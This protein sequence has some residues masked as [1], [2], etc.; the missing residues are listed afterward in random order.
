MKKFFPIVLFL[1]LFITSAHAQTPTWSDDVATI[2]YNNCSN[3]HRDGGIGP[4]S[5]MSYEEAVSNSAGIQ[6]QVES[7]LMPPWKPDP[8]Y[9]HFKDERQL[10]ETEINTLVAWVNGDTPLGDPGTAPPAPVFP[11]GSQLTS[12]DKS[13]VTPDYTIPGEEDHYRTFVIESGFTTEEFLNKIEY[14]PGNGSI[15]HHIVLF[16]D[17]TS[18]SLNKDLGDPL[19]GYESFG[20]GPLNSASVIIGAWAPGSSIFSL[21]S[22]MGIRIPPGAD[23]GVEMHYAPGSNGQSDISTVNLKFTPEQNTIR[24]VNVDAM[25][26]HFT[27]LT[28][29]PL[30]IPANTVKTFH[31]SFEW[32]YGDISVLSI[33]PH[34]HRIGTSYKAWTLND[35][36]DTTR[37]INIPDWSFHWQGFYDFQKPVHI[38]DPSAIQ[39]VATF[40]NTSNNPDN[41]SNPPQDVEAGEHTTDEMMLAFIAWMEYEPGDENIILDSTIISSVPVIGDDMQTVQVY[42]NPAHDHLGVHIGLQENQHVLFEL[43]NTSGSLIVEWK[44]YLQAGGNYISKSLPAMSSGLY[45]LKISMKNDIHYEKVVIE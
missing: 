22:N 41:P 16:Y 36:G 17:P 30:F 21:P 8:T 3:C 35:D 44:Q 7:K 15:V 2:I 26:S 25:L 42:P 38:T 43:I 19:P 20:L 27:D 10:T 4:F 5:L 9:T 28:N 23:F 40:D 11:T 1:F 45:F 31:E 39:A 34:M 29:G 24:K 37:L 13:L 32:E 12:I 14:L 18:Y 6:S 33:F